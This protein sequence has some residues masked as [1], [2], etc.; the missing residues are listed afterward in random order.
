MQ[1]KANAGNSY[2][3]EAAGSSTKRETPMVL[4]MP[5]TW[6][7]YFLVQQTQRETYHYIKQKTK[8]ST[9]TSN[10]GKASATLALTIAQAILTSK[11]GS[12]DEESEPGSI[13]CLNVADTIVMDPSGQLLEWA[14]KHM[15]KMVLPR[16]AAK[17]LPKTPPAMTESQAVTAQMAKVLDT[18]VTIQQQ[19][20]AEWELAAEVAHKRD[21][22]AEDKSVNAIPK[23][24]LTNLL[25]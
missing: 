25:G 20:M 15:H 3:M 2:S 9:K 13:L 22:K 7:A 12:D 23:V 14:T 4:P 5:I 17:D 8:E 11:D 18:L 16:E 24:I 21:A 1:Y 6:I 19:Q 10:K